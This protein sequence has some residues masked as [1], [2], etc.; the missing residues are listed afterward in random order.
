ML[1]S[2]LTFTIVAVAGLGCTENFDQFKPGAGGAATSTGSTSTS[3]SS[4]SGSTSSSSSSGAS[5]STSSSSSS[6]SASSSASSSS[7]GGGPENCTNGLDDDGNG[8]TDCAD[9]ACTAGY[10]CVDDVPGSWNG[11]V[12]LY[13]G[14]TANEPAACPQ[15]FTTKAYEGHS[16]I[17]ATPATC[18]ACSCDTPI[19]TCSAGSLALGDTLTCANTVGTVVQP[20]P[21]QCGSIAAP[22]GT[23]AYSAP[24]PTGTSANCNPSGGAA[25]L[26]PPAWQ[27]AGLACTGGGIG[28][29]CP[30]SQA[31]APK[32]PA[33]FQSGL[34]VW[35]SGDASCPA[36]F[37]QKHTFSNGIIDSRHCESCSCGAPAVSCAATSTL[38]KN[39]NCTGPSID[40]PN[41]GSCVAD[42][43]ST[44][45]KLAVSGT[46]SCVPGGG[47]ALGMITEN[48][49]KTTVCCAP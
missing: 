16:G 17:I 46:S 11:P 33:P 36:G 18:S 49:Q 10:A 26:P 27:G 1:R 25:T 45:V 32:A 15:P 35:K 21:G 4:S 30:P 42:S 9:P 37:G 29:G 44:S 39:G 31:C 38:Y 3:T 8:K 19:P 28:L 12:A 6:S 5:S 14:A 47:Q 2:A 24:T 13:D 41:D 34:C 20:A 48:A 22:P 40:V 23:L 7:S 43:G